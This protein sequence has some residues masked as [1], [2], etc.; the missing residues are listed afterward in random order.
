MCYMIF[1][2]SPQLNQVEEYMHHLQLPQDTRQRVIDYY[3]HRFKNK[4]FN[5]QQILS[6]LSQGLQEV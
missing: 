5:E 2:N 6:E 1:V 3:E 4:Y